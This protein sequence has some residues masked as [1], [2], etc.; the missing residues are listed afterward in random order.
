MSEEDVPAVPLEKKAI[1]HNAVA[2]L[3]PVRKTPLLTSDLLHTAL[4]TGVYDG[5]SFVLLLDN[6]DPY[7]LAYKELVESMRKKGLDAG[8][9]IFDGTPYCGKINRVA[10]IVSADFVCVI[11]STHLPMI[12]SGKKVS[13]AVQE[14]AKTSL[15]E[16]KVGSFGEDGFYPLVSRKL[17]DRLGYLFHPL[18]YG[19]IEAENWLLLIA[20]RLEIGTQI[21]DGTVIESNADGV[22]IVGV[23]D[24]EDAN[25][26]DETLGQIVDD[27]AERLEQYLIR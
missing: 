5:C 13:E 27:E 9:F 14:W 3:I 12:S 25:W 15:Q 23:S 22:E 19:R 7:L 10:P 16:M 1:D 2:F 11:D 21:P 6:D 17:V 20:S 26:V 8:Y 4:E 24:E 18:C